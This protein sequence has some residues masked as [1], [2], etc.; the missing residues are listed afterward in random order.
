M[1]L[2][3]ADLPSRGVLPTVVCL[4]SHLGTSRRRMPRIVLGSCAR[5]G[6]GGEIELHVF[7]KSEIHVEEPFIS[8]NRGI[9]LMFDGAG[10]KWRY[11]ATKL[12]DV[13]CHREWIF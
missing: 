6:G 13:T 10:L 12:H 3:R 8:I 4:V 1:S 7:L 2:R 5:R 11:T 9:S